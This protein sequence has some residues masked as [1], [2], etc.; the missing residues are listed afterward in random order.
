MR[1]PFGT[2]AWGT[3][4]LVLGCYSSARSDDDGAAD[5]GREDGADFVL[6]DGGREV[7]DEPEA[8][9]DAASDA[10]P[11]TAP[12]YWNRTLLTIDGVAEAFDGP[13]TEGQSARVVVT[14]DVGPPGCLEPGRV[15]VWENWD[16]R[17]VTVTVEGWINVDA[18][19]G[20]CPPAEPATFYAV[21]TVL[22]AG[23]WLVQAGTSSMTLEVLPCGGECACPGPPE[24]RPAWSD[25]TLD[26]QCEGGLACLGYFDI[27]GRQRRACLR[28]CNDPVECPWGGTCASVDDGP[29]SVCGASSEDSCAVSTDC[30]AGWACEEAPGGSPLR[31]VPRMALWGRECCRSDD[32]VAGQDC[33]VWTD[34]VGGQNYQCLVRCASEF[35][36]NGGFCDDTI[37]GPAGV[38]FPGK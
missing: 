1:F 11:C 35:A 28:S 23:T 10:A 5:D 13:V 6:D 38:C 17:T 24:N 25:C 8:A 16:T 34:I 29:L 27:A 21:L 20:A 19:A 3:A 33:V 26:C 9:D 22:W 7:A 15:L 36:C 2:W 18:L 31:C 12:Q 37:D 32:C 30:P 14:A 4:A